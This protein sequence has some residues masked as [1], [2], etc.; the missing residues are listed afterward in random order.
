MVGQQVIGF[1]DFFTSLLVLLKDLP[2]SFGWSPL[3]EQNEKIG[4]K[5]EKK[6]KEKK[7]NSSIHGTVY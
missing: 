1:L 2:K 3:L 7:R 5:K 4:K 6:R